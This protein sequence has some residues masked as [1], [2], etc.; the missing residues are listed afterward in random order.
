MIEKE[1]DHF[2]IRETFEGKM[3]GNNDQQLK[4]GEKLILRINSMNQIFYPYYIIVNF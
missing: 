3:K 4:Q 1:T 2:L